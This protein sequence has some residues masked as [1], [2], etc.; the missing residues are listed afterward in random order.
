MLIHDLNQPDYNPP[1]CPEWAK[2]TLRSLIQPFRTRMSCTQPV[3]VRA[4]AFACAG[5]VA[6]HVAN[7][8]SGAGAAAPRTPWRGGWGGNL[9]EPEKVLACARET[10]FGAL[11]VSGAPEKLESFARLARAAGI[12]TYFWISATAGTSGLAQVMSPLEEES[13]QR[14]AADKDRR[15]TRYQ[16]GGEPVAYREGKPGAPEVLYSRLLC[17]HRAEAVE[18]L[19]KQIRETLEAC[20]SLAGVAFDYFGYQNYRSCECPASRAQFDAWRREHPEVPAERAEAQFSLETLVAFNN[21]L[22]AYVRSL[23]PGIRIVTHVYPVFLPD[24]LYGNRLDVDYC[25]QTVAWFFEPYWEAE[26]IARYT[27]TVVGE[28]NKHLPG[29]RGIPFVGL[30]VG[31]PYADKSVAQFE[32]ELDCLFAAAGD[33]SLSICGFADLVEHAEY[34]KALLRAVARHTR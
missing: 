10:G 29:A 22:S 25:C 16:S 12:D 24:P 33:T 23:R 19:R 14:L 8:A 20:P 21:G 6:C 13:F 7:A 28:A 4:W 31:R 32:A 9:S 18:P 17:F 5:V 30:Y 1:D 27:R 11:M 3:R 15:K 2:E 26:K 34:R